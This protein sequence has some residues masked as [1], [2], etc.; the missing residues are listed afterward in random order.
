MLTVVL[1]CV[2][3]CSVLCLFLSV[4]CDSV[5]FHFCFVLSY[6]YATSVLFLFCSSSVLF[7]FL[8]TSP[9]PFHSI[10][11]F[12]DQGCRWREMRMDWGRPNEG[13]QREEEIKA[14]PLK[15][16]VCMHLYVNKNSP[17]P[18]RRGSIWQHIGSPCIQAGMKPGAQHHSLVGVGR[19]LWLP[20]IDPSRGGA[21]VVL[22]ELQGGDLVLRARCASFWLHIVQ[23]SAAVGRAGIG[24]LLPMTQRIMS[25][26]CA[27]LV[28]C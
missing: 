11:F 24:R 10:H 26:V 16:A 15:I 22:G 3:F 9:L 20:L 13:K 19:N 1:C 5:P 2:L 14:A 8:S 25:T 17:H 4:Q 18:C 7:L 27:H 23:S 6:L 21:Q 12:E 28:C